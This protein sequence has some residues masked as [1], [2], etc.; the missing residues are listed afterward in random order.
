MVNRFNGAFKMKKT[1][2]IVVESLHE[3]WLKTA[4]LAGISGNQWCSCKLQEMY[5][6]YPNANYENL[7][8]GSLT[9]YADSDLFFVGGWDN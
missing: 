3:A 1:V 4:P 6:R 7:F 8:T 9:R 5:S 2:Y